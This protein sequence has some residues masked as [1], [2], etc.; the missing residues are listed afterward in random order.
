M[1]V[2]IT[3]VYFQ[4]DDTRGAHKKHAVNSFNL[5]AILAAVILTII[6]I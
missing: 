6:D 5:E 4:G 2:V 3:W 1:E